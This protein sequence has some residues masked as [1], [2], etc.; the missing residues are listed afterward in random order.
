MSSGDYTSQDLEAM[1]KS[2]CP[3]CKEILDGYIVPLFLEKARLAGLKISSYYI[4]VVIERYIVSRA[5]EMG[6]LKRLGQVAQRLECRLDVLFRADLYKIPP[7]QALLIRTVTDP[8][9]STYI[10]SPLASLHGERLPDG[11]ASIMICCDQVNMYR[12]L[13]RNGV[14]LPE[15]VF[16]QKS[17]P[18]PERGAELLDKMATPWS[19]ELPIVV[20]RCM[21]SGSRRHGTSFVSESVFCG[22]QIVWWSNNSPSLN[23]IGEWVFWL[24][25][26][27]PLPRARKIKRLLA[28]MDD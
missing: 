2:V 3:T 14:P 17:A 9:N 5:E 8:L 25:T 22:A 15:T 4:G 23:L 6:P 1:D 13:L 26:T 11:P 21:S 7:Y 27:R 28:S 12:H 24:M 16:L 18:A 20:S 19:S 10:T